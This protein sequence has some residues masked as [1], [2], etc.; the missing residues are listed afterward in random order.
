[1]FDHITTGDRV[2]SLTNTLTLV[3]RGPNS[4]LHP[5][6]DGIIRRYENDDQSERL[7]VPES[8]RPKSQP[9]SKASASA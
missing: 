4:G 9:T 5:R 3:A 8:L 7:P 1:M 6:N 2:E